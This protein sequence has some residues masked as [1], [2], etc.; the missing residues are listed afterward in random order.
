MEKSYVI[1][2][3]YGSDS[4]RAVLVD[5]KDG[6]IEAESVFYYPRWKEGRFCDPERNMFRQHPLDYTEGLETTVKTILSSC[7]NVNAKDIKGIA[8]DTTGSTPCAVDK[9]GTPLALLPEFAENPNAM[10]ILWKDHTAISEAEQINYAA[11]TSEEDDFTKYVGGVYSSE[12]FWAKM[13]H[14]IREDESVRKNAA[15][16]VEHCDWIPNLLTGRNSIESLYRSRC[17]AGH[18]AMWN[19]E[20]D[21]LP[22]EEFLV[23]VDPLLKGMRAKLYSKTQT[24]DTHVGTLCPEWAKKLG[25]P[26]TVVVG[27]SAFDAHMGAIGGEIRPFDMVKV[28]G[29]STCDIM[30]APKSAVGDKCVGGICGQVEGSVIPGVVG[31]EAGQSAFGD[32]YAWFR[33]LLM[34]PVKTFIS[35]NETREM[36]EDKMLNMLEKEAALLSPNEDIIALDWFN[37]RRTPYANQNLKGAMY[38]LTLATDAPRIYR[39][40]IESTAFGARAILDRFEEEQIPVKRIIAIGGVARKSKLG[41]QILSDIMNREILV[42][43]SDQAVA[44]GAA[45]FAAVSSGVHESLEEAQDKMGGGYSDTFSPRPEVRDI[46]ERMYNRYKTFGSFIEK[47]TTGAE[48]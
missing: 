33:N 4:V 5:T 14:V 35:E 7:V 13:L 39:A 46:Y 34:W 19:E 30:V 25:L 45:M 41:M 40:L 9:T 1:G 44:L 20:F 29:T 3:D 47:N 12:W 11:K 48:K 17:A 22:S 27:G 32:V 42:S 6:K 26:E 21:G 10:F 37:G 43:A 23:S 8:V 15:S 16:W 24:A 31:L 28:I 18:K 2:V 36:I 38:G